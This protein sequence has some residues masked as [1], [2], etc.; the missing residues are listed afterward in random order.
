MSQIYV[1]HSREPNEA[2]LSIA[3]KS[4]DESPTRAIL[5]H[6]VSYSLECAALYLANRLSDSIFW[7]VYHIFFL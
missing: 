5:R 7:F 3:C 4:V 1:S 6:Q 2:V